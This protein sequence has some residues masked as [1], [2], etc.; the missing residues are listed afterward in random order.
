LSEAIAVLPLVAGQEGQRDLLIQIAHMGL[1]DTDPGSQC[2]VHLAVRGA[3]FLSPPAN[4]DDD[5]VAI[6]GAG[7][8]EALPLCGEQAQARADTRG[9]RAAT[10]ST[11]HREDTIEPLRGLIPRQIVARHEEVATMG[12]GQE[13]RVINHALV[14]V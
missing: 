1:R 3:G 13:L 14:G 11:R 4:V 2:R 6:G 7:R 12:T 5:V 9:V 10:R 8:R